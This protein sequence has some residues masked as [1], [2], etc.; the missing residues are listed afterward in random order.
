[1]SEQ[2][3]NN[4]TVFVVIAHIKNDNGKIVEQCGFVEQLT[5]KGTES[6]AV[7]LDYKNKTIVKNRYN[8]GTFHDFS[9]YLHNNYPQQM[10][11][12]ARIYEGIN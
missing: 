5:E 8:E 9:R 1:M 11:E 6:A 7:I 12:L 4:K 3:T 2:Q 10:M